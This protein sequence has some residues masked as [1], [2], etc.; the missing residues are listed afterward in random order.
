MSW[1]DA[2]DSVDDTPAD[3][4]DVGIYNAKLTIARPGQTRAGKPNLSF[5]FSVGDKGV[6]WLN[7]N[8][9]S[10]PDA[11]PGT[12][13]ACKG[14]FAKLGITAEMMDADPEAALNSA[15]GK[16]FQIEVVRRG[17][18]LNTRVIRQ[19]AEGE[20]PAPAQTAPSASGAASAPW[21]QPF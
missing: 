14:L 20:N 15:V 17:E 8:D 10:V 6:A 9:P 5:M 18:Y 11:H 1:K 16:D 21:E 19:L 13:A 7:Q 3:R 2:F 4:L 12:I